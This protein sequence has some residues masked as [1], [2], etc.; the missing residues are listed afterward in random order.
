MPRSRCMARHSLAVA[1]AWSSAT[2]PAWADAPDA[3]HALFDGACA[4]CHAPGS[5]RVL[6]G[7]P[8]LARKPAITE[9]DPSY[10]IRIVLQGRQPP[11]EQRGPWMPS[12]ATMLSDAQIAD[13]LNWLR[14]DAGEPP[15]AGLQQQVKAQR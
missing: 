2:V 15:W 3:G 7:Q 1:L 4:G 13:I 6:S 14:R 11:A 5:P 9:S 10:A 8:V 12:F